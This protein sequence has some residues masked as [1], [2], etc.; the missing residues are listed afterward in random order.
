MKKIKFN[1]LAII[2]MVVAMATVAFTKANETEWYEIE[3]NSV[4]SEHELKALTSAPAPSDDCQ[5]VVSGEL[6]KVEIEAGTTPPASV[7]TAA[8]GQI[9]REAKIDL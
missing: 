7:E 1:Y 8:S 5:I 6:C 2:G 4:T 9:L 3:F